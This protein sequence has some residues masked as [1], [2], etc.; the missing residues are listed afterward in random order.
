MA[1]S[2]RGRN[3]LAAVGLEKLI[4]ESAIPMKGRLLHDL[5]GR[6]TSVPYDALTG[7]VS[8]NFLKFFI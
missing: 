2:N 6:T 3:A 4:L 1:L 5:K 7:Q 8:T